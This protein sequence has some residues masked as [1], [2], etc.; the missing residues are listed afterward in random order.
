MRLESKFHATA[1]Y[2]SLLNTRYKRYTYGKESFASSPE[3]ARDKVHGPYGAML[4]D[5]R[6]RRKRLEVIA[7]D[8]GRCRICGTSY[9]LQVHHRQYHFLKDLQKYKAPWN[10]SMHLMVTL[11]EK[12]HSRGHARYKVPTI[13]L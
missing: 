9:N 6:W 2:L 12:C 13:Y 8:H 5:K 4:F 11:C 3:G 1:A 7:R 10:Y